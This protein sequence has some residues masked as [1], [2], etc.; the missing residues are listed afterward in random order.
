[1]ALEIICTNLIPQNEIF[2]N[3]LSVSLKLILLNDVHDFK[4]KRP[5][6]NQRFDLKKDLCL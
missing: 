6:D 1:M 5:S 4:S 2:F 3:Y